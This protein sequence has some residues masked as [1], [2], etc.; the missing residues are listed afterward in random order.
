MK[1]RRLLRI[2]HRDLGYFI[3]GMTVVYVVSGIFLNHRH[4][5]SPDYRIVSEEITTSS[6]SAES[7]DENAVVNLL[8]QFELRPVYR[9]HYI[10]N[11]G[12]VKVFIANG[13]VIIFPEKNIAKLTCLKRRPVIFE[14]NALH[15]SSIGSVW[16][17]TSDTMSFI[18]L[19]VAVSG[20]FLL[21]GKKGFVKWGWIWT[22]LGILIPVIF[23]L[24][25][26]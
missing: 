26:I 21:K 10:T 24:L 4:D 16:K 23:A 11:Q 20:L 19:F 18:L 12:N 15:K 1:V 13:E 6:L 5:F 14:M 17:W 25:F 7:Y 2:L 9:K 3:V 22:V 8:K